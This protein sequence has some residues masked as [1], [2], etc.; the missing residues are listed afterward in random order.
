MDEYFR[1]EH[2][3]P[4]IRSD[5]KNFILSETGLDT[6]ELNVETSESFLGDAEL[7]FDLT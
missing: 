7:Q 5:C 6:R 1:A 3:I 4:V 2:R